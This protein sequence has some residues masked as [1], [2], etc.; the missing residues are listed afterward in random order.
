MR[1]PALRQ[2]EQ[3]FD[4]D[5]DGR[6]P[7]PGGFQP[8]LATRSDDHADRQDA[9]G[10]ERP[11]VGRGAAHDR[12]DGVDRQEAEAET[13]QHGLALEPVA[14][15]STMPMPRPVMIPPGIRKPYWRVAA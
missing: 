12:V 15:V 14:W 13:E 1:C 8:A 11:P 6:P 2:Q 10:D 7:A 3:C 5:Q 4:D 9:A